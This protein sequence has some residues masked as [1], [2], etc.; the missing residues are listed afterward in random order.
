MQ[1]SQIHRHICILLLNDNIHLSA[2]KMHVHRRALW[3]V[4]SGGSSEEWRGSRR[5]AAQSG[6]ALEERVRG[7][8][9]VNTGCCSDPELFIDGRRAQRLYSNFWD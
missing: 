4:V 6:P 3:S 5:S 1:I 2:K 7:M 9:T 8:Y